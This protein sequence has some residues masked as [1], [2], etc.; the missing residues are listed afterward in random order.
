MAAPAWGEWMAFGDA[1]ARFLFLNWLFQAT[2]VLGAGLLVSRLPRLRA[3]IRHTVLASA[4]LLAAACPFLQAV[5]LPYRMQVRA[6]AA[7]GPA[8]DSRHAQR[9]PA[10][11]RRQEAGG[12]RQEAGGRGQK[13]EGSRIESGGSPNPQSAIPNP[14]SAIPWG[15]VLFVMWGGVAAV[16]LGSLAHGTW[17]VNRWMRG[18]TPADAERVY[19]ACGCALADIRVLETDAVTVPCVAGIHRPCILLPGGMLLSLPIL[20]LTH[21]LLHEEAHARRRDPLFYFLAELCHALLFWHPLA[22]LA[23]RSME[24]AAE[25]A[26]DAQVLA[27]GV[28]GPSYART[29]LAVLEHAAPTRTRFARCPLGARGSELRRR[30]VRI[31][32]GIPPASSAMAALAGGALGMV[33]TSAVLAELGDR[34]TPPGLRIADF[35]LRIEKPSFNAE[36]RPSK[37]TDPPMVLPQVKAAAGPMK[38]TAGPMRIASPQSAIRSPQSP[39]PQSAIHIPQ[40]AIPSLPDLEP[41]GAGEGSVLEA[42]HSPVPRGGRRVVFVLDN[43]GSMRP[44]QAEARREVLRLA[45]RLGENDSFNVIAFHSE[46]AAFAECP[47]TP[48]DSSFSGLRAWLD[49]LPEGQ[50]TNVEA[51]LARAFATPDVTSVILISD[52]ETCQG[53]ARWSQVVA[54]VERENRSRARVL[55]LNLGPAPCLAAEEMPLKAG[56][57]PGPADRNYGGIQA[58]QRMDAALEP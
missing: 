43:S 40:S 50:G 45:Q 28:E 15:W 5:P 53:G 38:T 9:A 36:V 29:L 10:V 51:G 57:T 35:G 37:P 3:A 21:I 20:R 6:P 49:G 25:D 42:M 34:P 54:C 33:T 27:R 58:I 7:V 17:A 13:A 52:G 56:P 47:V 31:L 1:A 8:V 18:A 39:G 32:A 14:Q 23:R 11:G 2:L 46:A 26:C 24:A 19:A 55:A 12:R 41:V 4:L 44:Y 48:C 16:R 30:V 22:A